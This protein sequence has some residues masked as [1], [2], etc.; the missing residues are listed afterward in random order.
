MYIFIHSFFDFIHIVSRVE[1][2]KEMLDVESDIGKTL[3]I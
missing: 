1:D 2:N 3:F